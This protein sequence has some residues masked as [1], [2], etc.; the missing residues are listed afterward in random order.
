MAQSFLDEVRKARNV[1]TAILHK[2]A[3]S[4]PSIQRKVLLLPSRG[5]RKSL[6]DHLKREKSS[7]PLHHYFPMVPLINCSER[8]LFAVCDYSTPPVS[9]L[10]KVRQ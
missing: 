5:Y 10:T 8:R 1:N 9:A 4:S 6:S 2:R 3:V 7:H